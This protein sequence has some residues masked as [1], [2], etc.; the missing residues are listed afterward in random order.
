MLCNLTTFQGNKHTWLVRHKIYFFGNSIDKSDDDGV[1]IELA[2][3][4]LMAKVAIDRVII[5]VVV[6]LASLQ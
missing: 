3:K 6:Y 5:I 1:V 4:E 2:I